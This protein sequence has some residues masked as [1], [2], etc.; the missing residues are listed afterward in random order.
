M[1]LGVDI[2][3]PIINTSSIVNNLRDTRP[4]VNVVNDLNSVNDSD[5]YF[6]GYN[7]FLDLKFKYFSSS[8]LEFSNS[9]FEQIDLYG[10][11]N[12]FGVTTIYQLAAKAISLDNSDGTIYV[13]GNEPYNSD[14]LVVR[15]LT[16]DDSQFETIATLVGD[17]SSYGGTYSTDIWSSASVIYVAG[18]ITQTPSIIQ[19]IDGTSGSFYMVMSRQW[20]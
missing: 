20:F 12:N 5:H 6:G 15:K 2:T 17:S 11:K 9:T 3:Q 7:K 14:R 4:N 16:S 1:V 19:S 18:R 8:F 10:T 13:V